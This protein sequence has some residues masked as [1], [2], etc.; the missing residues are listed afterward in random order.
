MNREKRKSFKRREK[1]RGRVKKE[2]REID[3]KSDAEK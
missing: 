1:E 2:D 3:Q